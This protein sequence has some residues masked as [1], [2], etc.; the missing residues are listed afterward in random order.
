[1]DPAKDDDW[2][3]PEGQPVQVATERLTPAEW[4]LIKNAAT[5]AN[6]RIALVRDL[7]R[8]FVRLNAALFAGIGGIVLLEAAMIY[9]GLAKPSDRIVSSQVVM[10]LIGATA[11]Q[12]GFGVAAMIAY[13]FPKRAGSSRS[14]ADSQPEDRPGHE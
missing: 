14:A 7:T 11:V 3:K 2:G 1:M 13:L 6:L 8:L 5:D 12:L 4:V 9:L 10:T